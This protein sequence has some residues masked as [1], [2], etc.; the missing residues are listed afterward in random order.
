MEINHPG[1]KELS[2]EEQA[3]VDQFRQRLHER[4]V[5]V[6]LTVDDVRRIVEGLRQ[7]PSASRAALQVITEEARQRVPGGR[8]L[9]FDWD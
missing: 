4:V 9:T 1:E 6:G 3:L 5:S 7:H 2:P 8:L